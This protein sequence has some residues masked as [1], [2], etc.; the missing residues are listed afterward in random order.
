MVDII[1]ILNIGMEEENLDLTSKVYKLIIEHGKE[2]ILQSTLWKELGLTSRDGSRLAIR[3]EKRNIIRREKVLDDGRWTYLLIPL[4]L[5]VQIKSIEL[6][7]CI[8]CYD[9]EKCSSDGIVTPYKCT[10]LENWVI[11]EN[12]EKQS[13]EGDP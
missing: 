5:P 9:E 8:V 6:S 11:Q 7:P 4:K 2:G 13:S 3:L 10:E 1:N 12:R